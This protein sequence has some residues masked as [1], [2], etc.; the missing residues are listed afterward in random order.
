MHKIF[1]SKKEVVADFN[2]AETGRVKRLKL[3]ARRSDEVNKTLLDKC[4]P[5]IQD[6]IK[7]ILAENFRM[8]NALH[9]RAGLLC[10]A[11]AVSFD[12]LT[13]KIQANSYNSRLMQLTKSF[14]EHTQT[15]VTINPDGK[16]IA[17]ATGDHDELKVV[18]Y[19]EWCQAFD[20][21]RNQRVQSYGK[22]SAYHN[23]NRNER[24][25]PA[26][27][28]RFRSNSLSNRDSNRGDQRHFKEPPVQ[29]LSRD[30]EYDNDE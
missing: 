13:R 24:G 27:R 8:K 14:A 12:D 10:G 9:Q 28:G 18:Q 16:M 4:S 3:S 20:I 30:G 6:E 21:Y 22:R 29:A 2:R 15:I 7:T 25:N 11:D 26:N 23:D 17:M 19:P 1:A 5:E